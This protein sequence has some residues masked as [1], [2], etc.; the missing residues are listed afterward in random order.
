MHSSV[1]LALI[2]NNN[3]LRNDYI[4]TKIED[5]I[6]NMDSHV[7]VKRL[8]VSYQSEIVPHSFVMAFMRDVI[9]QNLGCKW[10]K[11]RLLR[12]HKLLGAVNFLRV[13]FVK[14]ILN[15]NGAAIRWKR[16]SAIEVAVTDKHI[17]AWSHFLDSDSDYLIIFE[18]DVVF[19]DDSAF[20]LNELLNTLSKN[21]PNKACYADL[22]GGCKLADLMID[23]LET[24]QDESYR[25]YKK[26]VTN[27]A[28]AYLMSREL[29]AVFIAT[30]TRKPWLRLVGVDWLMNSLFILCGERL[31]DSICMHADPTIF[32]HGTTTGEYVSWQS[33][34]SN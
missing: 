12:S 6:S 23:R 32:K 16:Y 10:R 19:K 9:Y 13:S 1:C 21:Y 30:L 29:V 25:Y 33:D 3:Q 15:R 11:Y 34:V 7:L 5:L 31:L 2:H 17:R 18:D 27:T 14:Y 28:C 26:P 20:R 22:G 24:S 8:E 4:R